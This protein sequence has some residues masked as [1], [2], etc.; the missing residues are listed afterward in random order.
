MVKKLLVNGCS[1]TVESVTMKDEPIDN[2][3]TLLAR[4][5][6]VLDNYTN[7]ALGGAGNDRIYRTTIEYL[8]NLNV[9][10][11]KDLMVII[12]WSFEPRRE[13]KSDIEPP[14]AIWSGGE[15]W[16]ITWEN[17]PYLWDLFKIGDRSNNFFT[18]TAA[19][20]VIGLHNILENL[21]INNYHFF[22]DK[23]VLSEIK[24]HKKLLD[25]SKFYF[26]KPYHTF[27]SDYDTPNLQ[28]DKISIDDDHPGPKS[29]RIVS[30]LLFKILGRFFH[31]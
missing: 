24:K 3:G 27:N 18:T 19:N 23:K 6:G 15:Y 28:I 11:Y 12:C 2:W 5:L 17:H 25:C 1:F 4:K 13:Y 29:K 31:G 8:E 10:Y 21:N 16:P 7:L 22:A 14:D 26:D 9:K 20:Y 30:E